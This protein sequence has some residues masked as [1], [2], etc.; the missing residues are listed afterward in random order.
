MADAVDTEALTNWLVSLRERTKP[1]EIGLRERPSSR[2]GPRV[3]GVTQEQVNTALNWGRGTYQAL[4]KGRLRAQGRRV[5]TEHILDIAELFKLD[6][7]KYRQLHILAL[8]TQPPHSLRPDTSV[9]LPSQ[10]EWQRVVD[11]QR[12]IAYVTNVQ[13]DL[14]VWNKPFTRLFTTL[15]DTSLG[16]TEGRGVPGNMMDFM[17]FSRLAREELLTDWEERWAPPVLAQLHTVSLEN[18]HNEK[19]SQLMERVREDPITRRIYE[20][21]VID[22]AYPDGDQRPL[23]HPDFG[24]G[25]AAL[26]SAHPSSAPH[27]RLIVV[28]FTPLTAHMDDTVGTTP[29]SREA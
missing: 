18:P 22:Y 10:R 3:R 28:C 6:E 17:L 4:E 12:E 29:L 25:L 2:P 7:D 19:L 11:G 27:A 20:A 24:R 23:N 21:G 5:R 9:V 13:W 26:A 15:G 8:G 14:V 1:S 16:D